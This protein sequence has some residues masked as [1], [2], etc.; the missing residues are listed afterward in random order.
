M[1]AELHQK[2]LMLGFCF[3][4]CSRN[5]VLTGPALLG[6]LSS[7]LK[8]PVFFSLAFLGFVGCPNGHLHYDLTRRVSHACLLLLLENQ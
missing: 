8:L 3:I 4:D 7:L 1:S 6:T 5:A 2:R